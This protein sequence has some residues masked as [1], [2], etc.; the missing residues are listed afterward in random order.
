MS[1]IVG[2]VNPGVMP[3]DEPLLRLMTDSLAHRGP[4]KQQ[5]WL[6]GPVGF[7]HTLLSTTTE[8]EDEAQPA[9][10]DG[11]AEL[12]DQL[13][14]VARGGLREAS[15]AELILHAY[16]AWAENCVEHLLGDF[17]FAI[18]DGPARRLFCARDHF[19]VK[20]FYYARIGGAIVFSNSLDCVRLHPAVRDGLNELAIGDFLLFGFN[21]DPTTTTFADVTEPLPTLAATRRCIAATDARCRSEAI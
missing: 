13:A 2:I 9:S 4:D 10:L 14:S 21:Q 17:A 18:W 15:D 5:T 20:P 11:R 19:G 12:V 7:G 1:G 3:V 6:D 8:S 16:H